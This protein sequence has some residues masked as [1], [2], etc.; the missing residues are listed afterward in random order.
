MNCAVISWTAPPRKPPPL[1]ARSE[2]LERVAEFVGQHAIGFAVDADGGSPQGADLVVDAAAEGRAAASADDEDEKL[3]LGGNGRFLVHP[4]ERVDVK[5]VK[6]FALV[7]AAVDIEAAAL[8]LVRGGVVAIFLRPEQDEIVGRFAARVAE[9]A[10]GVVEVVALRDAG[11]V[12]GEEDLFAGRACG[13]RSFGRG[14]G[15]GFG[16]T[17]KDGS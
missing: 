6:A 9:F 11:D 4:L 15:I 8:V 1:S 5:V 3:V 13:G 16:R 14:W 12:F 17:Q 10:L 7:E 2:G